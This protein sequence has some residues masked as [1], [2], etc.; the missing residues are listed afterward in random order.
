MSRGGSIPVSAKVRWW[1]QF[2]RKT[3]RGVAGLYRTASAYVFHKML[4]PVSVEQ[5][6]T[7]NADAR[8]GTG[9]ERKKGASQV[10]ISKPC[11]NASSTALEAAIGRLMALRP[12]G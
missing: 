12:E 10:Y 2:K 5:Q 1:H 8:T 7:E 9:K 3:I 6:C 11:A 4:P